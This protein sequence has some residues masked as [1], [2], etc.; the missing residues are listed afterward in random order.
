MVRE[1]NGMRE[2]VIDDGEGDDHINYE[3]RYVIVSSAD[4]KLRYVFGKCSW[5][6]NLPF[7]NQNAEWK[8]I[9][10]V[11]AQAMEMQPKNLKHLYLENVEID[12]IYDFRE[13]LHLEGPV[14]SRLDTMR[15]ENL[16]VRRICEGHDAMTLTFLP[17]L[18]I[19]RCQRLEFILPASICGD[20]TFLY[21]LV[22]SNCQN[23][24][25]IVEKER[26]PI[27]RERYLP[28]F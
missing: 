15:L 25:Y 28:P 26:D 13:H 14:N 23:L 10:S 12:V 2:I 8:T 21:H 9:Y 5:E 4:N 20:L 3:L 19:S 17:K 16:P 24:L 11:I 1:S 6:D 27:P 18:E 22:V 7:Q